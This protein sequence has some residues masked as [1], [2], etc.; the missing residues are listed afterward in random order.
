MLGNND[1]MNRHHVEN[2]RRS[3][4]MLSPGSPAFDR[5]EGMRLLEAIDSLLRAQALNANVPS[6]RPPTNPS[7]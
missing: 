5:E 7:R 3:L 4:A 6:T 1:L 2:L